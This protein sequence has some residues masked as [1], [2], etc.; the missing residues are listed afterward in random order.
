MDRPLLIETYRILNN[1]VKGFGFFEKNEQIKAL[2]DVLWNDFEI[3]R[4]EIIQETILTIIKHDLM[5]KWN[6]GSLGWYLAGIMFNVERN[7]LRV[8][9]AREKKNKEEA[10]SRHL[11]DCFN[12]FSINPEERF[13][14]TEIIGL[15][16]S[17]MSIDEVACLVGCIS[18][19]DLMEKSGLNEN[20]VKNRLKYCR[21]I[22]WNLLK[23]N[24]YDNFF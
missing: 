13:F 1:T 21:R 16:N 20:Q 15:L 24:G 7:M 22:A 10:Y 3:D 11:E 12:K 14:V 18:K 8:E 6:G 23:K 2:S 5:E 4:Q 9:R 19:H 17:V